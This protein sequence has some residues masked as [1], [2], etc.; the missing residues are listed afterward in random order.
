MLR[1]KLC[2]LQQQRVTQGLKKEA[3]LMFQFGLQLLE[4]QVVHAS[5]PLFLVCPGDKRGGGT[6]RRNNW[7]QHGFLHGSPAPCSASCV[8]VFD[9]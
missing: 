2:V 7:D 8:V 6:S 3:N 5:L 9:M 4:S 1:T